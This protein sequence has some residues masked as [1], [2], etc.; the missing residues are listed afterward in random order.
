MLIGLSDRVNKV[1]ALCNFHIRQLC[2]IQWTLTDKV[3]HSLV[4]AF[5]LD[6]IDYCNSIWLP[7]RN[8][9][10]RS[11]SVATHPMSA[12]FCIDA[13]S[14]LLAERQVE[15]EVH[16]CSR[17]L[18]VGSQS[19]CWPTMFQWHLPGRSH[20]RS[21]DQW[22]MLVPRI[23][24]VAIGPQ[25]FYSSFPSIWNSL[26]PSLHDFNLSLENFRWKLKVVILSSNLGWSKIISLHI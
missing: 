17:S 2:I 8:I 9:S 13:R 10:L 18:Q 6:Q 21:A 3:V 24:T 7:V 16:A 4:Q 5:I 15:S 1:A 19:T 14:T 23:K 25:G 22:T 12:Y 26:P 11:Y 20:F